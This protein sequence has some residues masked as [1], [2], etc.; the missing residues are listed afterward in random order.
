[1]TVQGWGD[2]TWGIGMGNGMD[3][4]SYKFWNT[5]QVPALPG[6]I[7]DLGEVVSIRCPIG[8]GTKA[9]EVK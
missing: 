5:S 3:A 8:V 6:P 2:R 9:P 7:L 1:M 4:H